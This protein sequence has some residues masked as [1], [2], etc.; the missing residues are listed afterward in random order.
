MKV[1]SLFV[2]ASLLATTLALPVNNVVEQHDKR[3]LGGLLGDVQ[4]TQDDNLGGLVGSILHRRLLDLLGGL[5]LVGGLLGGLSDGTLHKRGPMEEEKGNGTPFDPKLGGRNPIDP[6]LGGTHRRH[7]VV[8][9][10]VGGLLGDVLGSNGG[11]LS[12]LLSGDGLNGLLNS[13]L[14]LA[15]GAG[16]P[17]SITNGIGGLL[18]GL[19]GKGTQIPVNVDIVAVIRGLPIVG[20][21][22]DEVLT[23][24]LGD[25]NLDVFA[26]VK[27]LLSITQPTDPNAPLLE[28]ILGKV[29]LAL[30]AAVEV[31]L[32][33]HKTPDGRGLVE[34][35]VGNV[36]A[37]ATVV[38][39]ANA[40][41]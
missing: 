33:A 13:I 31:H 2:T 24:V 6:R 35:I 17:E 40:V 25:F 7:D 18:T 28:E 27:L 5:P 21:L 15:S 3:L 29:R 39:G 30:L 10:L 41:V 37:D 9:G 34:N 8:D 32:H 36:D 26:F 20:G 4:G 11:L 16:N 14:G 12:G 19:K 22:L 1:A 23:T 38:A